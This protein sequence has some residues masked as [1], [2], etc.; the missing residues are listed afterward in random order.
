MLRRVIVM[1]FGFVI[2][3][4]AGMVFLPI[5]ALV[6]MT[7]REAGSA[8]ALAELFAAM[9]DRFDEYGPDAAAA[10]GF[11]FWAMGVAVCAAPLAVVALIGEAAGT[12]AY[13]WY[14]GGC[15]LLGAAAPWI[16]RA[17]RGSARAAEATAAEGRFA[18][19][20]FLAGALT[21]S[22]YWLIAA[23]GERA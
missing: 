19:L 6:D 13:T 18:L 7:T 9:I 14:A 2:A 16:L 8:A 15:A 4:G 11:A 23:R 17:A 3:A 21:G 10:V 12:R 20:F 22:I 5:A 1:S